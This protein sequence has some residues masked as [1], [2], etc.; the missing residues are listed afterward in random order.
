MSALLKEATFDRI[1]WW[2][3][4]LIV[5]GILQGIITLV[6]LRLGHQQFL[7]LFP[8]H[9]RNRGHWLWVI[10]WPVG[11]ILTLFWPFLL[12][13]MLF[14]VAD[15][16]QKVVKE[17]HRTIGDVEAQAGRLVEGAERTGG[18]RV[19]GVTGK[20]GQVKSKSKGCNVEKA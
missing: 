7:S 1:K 4:L 5:W 10:S 2:Q 18:S 16:M 9:K 13:W 15:E 8:E 14:G 20:G 11:F 6:M 12:V 17:I 3:I 19:E